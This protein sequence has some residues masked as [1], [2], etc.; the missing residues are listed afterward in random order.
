MYDFKRRIYEVLEVSKFGDKSSRAYDK[1]M[2]VAIIVGLIPMMLKKE[3][4]Y[5]Y[6]I[7]ILTSFIF[8]TDYIARVYTADYKMGY[9]SYKAYIA[10]LFTPLAIFDFL[11]ILPVIYLFT[12][13]SSMI[14]L[15]RLFRIFRA[16]KLIRYSKTMIIIANVIRK[17]KSQLMAVLILIIVYIFVSAM[18]IFQL[19]PNLFNNFF[20]ALYW[21]TISITTIGYGDISPVTPIGRLITM[22]SALVGVAVIAL[23]S[24]IIT[25]AYM[26]EITKTKSKYEL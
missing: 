24:G 2:T 18:L 15:L 23:P 22:C 13:V 16:L 6:W 25:A 7:E 17:V 1:L 12:P 26:T 14:G 8:L 4:T 19:E 11:S 21:A 10:Y 9:K 20:D 5:T 3:T